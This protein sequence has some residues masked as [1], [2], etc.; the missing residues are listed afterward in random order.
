MIPI[1]WE[2]LHLDS[3]WNVD[4]NP[5]AHITVRT[6]QTGQHTILPEAIFMHMSCR[7]GI[8]SSYMHVALEWDL[9]QLCAHGTGMGFAAA[10][11]TWYRNWICSSHIHMI[12]SSYIHMA[13]EWD[14]Q[15]PHTHGTEW[16][17]QQLRTHGTGMGFTTAVQETHGVTLNDYTE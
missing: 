3:G 14:L 1:H 15:K 11:Y 7:N 16:D 8:C 10:T 2:C 4:Q 5:R 9:Q 13:L 6:N 17:L 12:C